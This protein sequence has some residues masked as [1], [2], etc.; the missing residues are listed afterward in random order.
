MVIAGVET[1]KGSL[2][3]G[4]AAPVAG[5]WGALG[6]LAG[7]YALNYADRQILSVLVEPI[8]AEMQL[9]DSQI[10]LLTGTLFALFYSILSLP[11]AHLADRYSR[12]RIVATAC[13]LW[14]LFTGFTGLA[15]NL[16]QLSIARIGVA[17]GE[18]GGAAPSLSLIGD[19]FA[20]RERVR[21][22][23]F[24]NAAAPLG[25][26]FG[27]LGGGLIAATYGW[28]WA[29]FGLAVIGFVAAPLLLLFLREPARER[30]PSAVAPAPEPF[31]ATVRLLFKRPS[32]RWLLLAIAFY[33]CAG[34]SALSWAPAL[35]IRQYGADLRGMASLY[36]P[37]VALAMFLS[38][39]TA[40]AVLPRLVGHSPRAY[41]LFPAATMLLCG[42]AF[43]WALSFHEWQAV[44]FALFV[45]FTL[46]NVL[47]TPAFA[48]VQELTPSSSRATALA[49]LMLALN[50]VGLGLGPLI[51]GSISD[52]LLPSTGHESLFWTLIF[53][54]PIEALLCAI[55]LYFCSRHV[56]SDLAQQRASLGA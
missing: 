54:V 53:V 37:V 14:S 13:F 19:Y 52:A 41:A 30:L 20:P 38:A 48:L 6:F 31:F 18:A 23:S 43:A 39:V 2:D 8:K 34:N 4:A 24:F 51:V 42:P 1:A 35:L 26:L 49:L 25:M 45:P 44:I 33:S 29:L 22:I 27:T 17:I 11:I 28:R 40:G 21:A 50:L 9:S 15:A 47:L 3:P 5:R 10:S 56:S 7:L 36:G 12:L 16:V 55:C 46:L 32:L